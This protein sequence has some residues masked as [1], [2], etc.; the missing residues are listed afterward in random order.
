MAKSY[1]VYSSPISLNP[2]IGGKPHPRHLSWLLFYFLSNS[3]GLR[4]KGKEDER[5]IL[6]LGAQERH[7]TSA[8]SVMLAEL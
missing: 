8:G 3:A 1:I 5:E 4:N 7:H 6:K 2:L